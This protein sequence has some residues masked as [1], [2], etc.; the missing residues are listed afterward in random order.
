LACAG[1]KRQRSNGEANRL[2][3]AATKAANWI[4]HAEEQAEI[5]G[6]E[7]RAAE[8]V[9]WAVLTAYGHAAGDRDRR[10]MRGGILGGIPVFGFS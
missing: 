4:A 6:P 1:R 10:W 9:A 5:F 3:L 2:A 8:L 7:S